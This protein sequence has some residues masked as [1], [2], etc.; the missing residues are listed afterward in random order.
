MR[1]AVPA[2]S[3]LRIGVADGDNCTIGR[4]VA[5][6]AGDIVMVHRVVYRGR[7]RRGRGHLIL[8][9][10]R[11]VIPDLPVDERRILGP[12]IAVQKDGVW[13]RPGPPYRPLSARIAAFV[14]A[15]LSGA[16]LEIDARLARLFIEACDRLRCAVSTKRRR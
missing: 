1:P 13:S 15:R 2:R 4:I 7:S 12:V 10:D 14:L 11:R 3:I 5:Y 6:M 9:G 8:C 16:L